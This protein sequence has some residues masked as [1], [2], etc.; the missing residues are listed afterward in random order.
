MNKEWY[1]VLVIS[2]LVSIVIGGLIALLVPIIGTGKGILFFSIGIS[3]IILVVFLGPV[4]KPIRDLLEGLK[5]LVGQFNTS[6]EEINKIL[7]D[8]GAS[9][10]HIKEFSSS[11]GE[12]SH[13]V[14]GLNK[15][16]REM[17]ENLAQKTSK[18]GIGLKTAFGVVARG[19]SKRGGEGN[20]DE[21]E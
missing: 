19:V 5:P 10:D 13:Q 18:F 16:I 7:K 2:I 9:V 11:V 1:K 17:G 20:K 14:R 6:M 4:I 12:M 8:V 3:V 21:K 15:Q